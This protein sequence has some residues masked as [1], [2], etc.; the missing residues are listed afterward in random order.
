MLQLQSYIR[1][2]AFSLIYLLQLLFSFHKV[3]H[4]P[5]SWIYG[6]FYYYFLF[7]KMCHTFYINSYTA[8]LSQQSA[9]NISNTLKEPLIFPGFFFLIIHISY[10]LQVTWILSPYNSMFLSSV[11]KL[12]KNTQ[13]RS[14]FLSDRC[15]KLTE[16]FIKH[17]V[18]IVRS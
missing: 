14:H 7:W 5:L 4:N 6:D 10:F 17:S 12:T 18:C 1:I 8:S 11:I 16:M 9:V 15:T 2:V 13:K 3:S